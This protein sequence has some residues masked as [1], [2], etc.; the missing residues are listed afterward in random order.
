MLRRSV[1][2][3][4]NAYGQFL[5]E[6]KGRDFGGGLK[7]ALLLRQAYQKL[8][9]ADLAGLKLR[10]A[11]AS[12]GAAAAAASRGPSLVP[13]RVQRQPTQYNY[14]VRA[15]FQK[16]KGCSGPERIIS[17]AKMWKL[18][19][20][21]NSVGLQHH[22]SQPSRVSQSDDVL[23]TQGRM[24]PEGAEETRASTTRMSE[25]QER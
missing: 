8:S 22:V 20:K 10:S 23:R 21:R 2:R 9:P 4:L 1:E 7:R 17:L 11:G 3:L 16:A 12:A 13:R 18:R 25:T 5:I 19:K 14:F 6:C 24:H 15:N